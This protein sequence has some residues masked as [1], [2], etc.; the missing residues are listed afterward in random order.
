MIPE[1]PEDCEWNYAWSFGDNEAIN[2]EITVP[3]V[4]SKQ[5]KN[6]TCVATLKDSKGYKI[7]SGTIYS[8]PV[9]VYPKPSAPKSLTL[10]GNGTSGTWFVNGLTGSGADTELVFGSDDSDDLD[11]SAHADDW[12]WIVS[13]PTAGTAFTETEKYFVYVKQYYS[14]DKV[15]ITSDRMYAGSKGLQS[16]D[17]S[18][19]KVVTRGDA[20]G[21]DCPL[22]PEGTS[23]S[24]SI[25]GV[26][27]PRMVRG[28]NII[29]MEDGT[30]KKV[31][32]K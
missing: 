24:Y 7:W 20:Q 30:V 8:K 27:T 23:A 12:S 3:N 26:R 4:S 14:E 21:I 13:K 1:K 32:K 28:L 16:W 29:R 6:L 5:Q 15:V 25:N 19:Y 11:I 2:N 9:T 17:G 18:D 10:K 31:F 22:L